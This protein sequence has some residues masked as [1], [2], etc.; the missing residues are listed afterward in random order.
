MKNEL[1][2]LKQLKEVIQTQLNG[3]LEEGI[4]LI[5]ERNVAIDFPDTDRMPKDTM[6]YI[7]PDN[8][9]YENLST[10]S[11]ASVFT[12]AVFVICKKDRQESLLVR[13]HGYFQALYYL[14]RNNLSLDGYVDFCE[15]DNAVMHYALEANENIRAVEVSVSVRYTKDFIRR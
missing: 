6:F 4:P 11:D 15:V 2:I 12:V 13:I 5:G 3:Y 10:E 9:E 14:L 7:L 1:T 8:A